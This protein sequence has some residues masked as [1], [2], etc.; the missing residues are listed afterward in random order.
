MKTV[1]PGMYIIHTCSQEI[2]RIVSA[3]GYLI[4]SFIHR[5]YIRVYIYIY[6]GY[7]RSA[8]TFLYDIGVS[9]CHQVW[10]RDSLLNVKTHQ[11]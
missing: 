3:R 8:H 1:P 7:N 6:I 2:D 11:I 5:A 10:S 9:K 4:N